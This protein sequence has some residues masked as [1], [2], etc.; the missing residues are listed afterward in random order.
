MGDSPKSMVITQSSHAVTAQWW[1]LVVSGSLCTTASATM[2][3]AAYSSEI[4]LRYAWWPASTL[5]L[6]L[7]GRAPGASR[8]AVRA[9]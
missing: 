9:R 7:T 8:R 6:Q 1:I 5:Q 2:S 4:C 3:T